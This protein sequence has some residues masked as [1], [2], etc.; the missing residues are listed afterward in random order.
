M[1]ASPDRATELVSQ[2]ILGQV[3]LVYDEAPG[4]LFIRTADE[5]EGW[6][7]SRWAVADIRGRGY[8]SSGRV[9]RISNLFA[10]ILTWPD[11][12]AD[13]ITK[14]VVG[15]ELETAD[16]R[17]DDWV[18][19]RLPDG[20]PGAVRRFAVELIDRAV[21][22]LPLTPTG[23]D[24]AATAKR[25]VG[26]PY[27]WGGVSAFGLDCSG[28]VQLVFKLHGM[29]IPRD[30]YLQAEDNNF[31]TVEEPFAPGDLIFFG[32]PDGSR[33]GRSITHVGIALGAGR[34]IHSS[35]GAG[36][37]VSEVDDPQYSRIFRLARRLL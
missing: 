11:P 6:I 19:V 34:F 3:A 25:F 14:A 24:L 17:D 22:P 1:R 2:V 32:K 13:I 36:V 37:M 26:A 20:K 9:A 23:F 18:I 10:E 29:L 28:L 4:W 33:T 21:Y 16:A 27:L 35:G 5:Y 7:E 31:R 15:T 12:T 8:A 30:A